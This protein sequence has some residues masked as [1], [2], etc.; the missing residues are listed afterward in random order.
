MENI[1]EIEKRLWTGA[2][3]L[4]AN[5]NFASNEYFLPVMGLIF[6]RHAYS[7]FLAVKEDIE[8]ELPKRGGQTRAL[9]KEDFSGKG[10]IFLRP[11]AQFDYLS[12]CP[13]AKTAPRP[14]SMRWNRS[15]RITIPRGTLPKTEYPELDNDVLGNLLRIFNDRRSNA[16]GDIF[17]RIYEYFLTQFADLKAHDGGE[18]F[19][20]ISL[21][22][23]DRQC[24]RT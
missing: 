2:D 8:A 20:P 18:F 12:A 11:E 4:R 9:T 5:S 10:A 1:G 3:T 14:S 15:K 7:R 19:T 22:Q 23:T 6:L 13:T 24:H 16:N 21:V 17:G